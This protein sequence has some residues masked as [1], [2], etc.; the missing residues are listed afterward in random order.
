MRARRHCFPTTTSYLM[1]L[2]P[3]AYLKRTIAEEMAE[4]SGMI[5]G[6]A[7]VKALPATLTVHGARDW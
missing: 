7:M 1:H 4:K 2:P 3:R 5:K 6:I